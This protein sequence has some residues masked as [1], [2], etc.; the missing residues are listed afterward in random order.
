[1]NTN[2][3]ED[4]W[5]WEEIEYTFKMNVIIEIFYTVGLDA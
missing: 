3:R 5:V 2:E 4:V 1:M